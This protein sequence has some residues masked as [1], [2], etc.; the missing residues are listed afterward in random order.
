MKEERHELEL[1]MPTRNSNDRYLHVRFDP[2]NKVRLG[3]S[4]DLFSPFEPRP[5]KIQHQAQGRQP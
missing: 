1:P 2:G 4:P 5:E 3:W